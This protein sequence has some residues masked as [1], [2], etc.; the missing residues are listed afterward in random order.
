M[1]PLKILVVDDAP[2]IRE[3][4]KQIL[5]DEAD[6]EVIGEATNGY[7]AIEKASSLHPDIIFMDIVMPEM[8]GIKATEEIVKLDPQIKIIA[9]TTMD[10]SAIQ[11]QALN[12]GCKGFLKKPFSKKEFLD[13]LKTMEH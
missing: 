6:Y 7:E 3:I 11:K 8:S 12:A 2:F 4:V 1:N 10:S 13:Y 9:F 5:S